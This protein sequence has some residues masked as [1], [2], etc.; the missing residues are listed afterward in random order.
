MTPR[1]PYR[2]G[3]VAMLAALAGCSAGRPEFVALSTLERP[4]SPNTYLVCPAE[5]TTATVDREPPAYNVSRDQLETAWLQALADEPRL[6]RR[7]SDASAHR[8]LFVQR[9]PVFRFPDVIQ[10]AFIEVGS[11]GATLCIY[12]RSVYGYSDLGKNRE[13]VE[14]WLARIAP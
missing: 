8:H 6:T 12:S 5:H 4:T 9:T 10:I 3:L 2:L 14:D 1:L 7:A 13:R 11:G